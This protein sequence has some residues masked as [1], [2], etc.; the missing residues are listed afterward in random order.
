MPRN[1]K[2]DA[3]GD[4]GS[5]RRKKS[6]PGAPSALPSKS[7][8]LDFLAEVNGDATRRDIARAFNIK[9]DARTELRSLLKEMNEEGL[10]NKTGPKRVQTPDAL[11]PILPLDIVSANADGDLLC[12]PSKW[13]SETTPPTIWLPARDAARQKPALG[14]GDR[15]LAR[16]RLA[17]DDGY[18]ASVIKAIGRGA[19]RFLAV[20][21]A[22]KFGGIAE[23]VE[24]RVRQKFTIDREDTKGAQ[25]GDLV[26]AE[27]APRRG[28]S[29]TKAR[30]Q[31]IAG[32]IDD[33]NAFS[34]MALANHNV[35]MDMPPAAVKEA[36]KAKAPTLSA[37]DDLR[38]TPL[39]TIDPADAKDHDD[40]VWAAPDD[41]PNNEGGFQVI[42][43]IA[44]VSWFVREGTALDREARRRGNSVYLPDRVVP[45]LPERLS[46]GLCSL[47]VG[48]DRPCLAV[49]MIIDANGHK[50]SHRFMRALMRS[51]SKLSYEEAQALIENPTD[52]EI[53]QTI[54]HLKNAFDARWRERTNRAPLDLD[55]PERRVV[56]NKEG[57]VLGVT[58][59]DRF[60]A[61]RVIEEFMILANIAAAET[62]EQKKTEQM[63]R[64][65]E[66]PDDEKLA[67]TRDYLS[68][69]DYSLIKGGAVRPRHF[70]QLLKL[71]ESRDQKE[72][73]SQIVLRSQMQAYYGVENF[74]HFGLKPGEILPFHLPHSALCGFNDPPRLGQSLQFR[75][76]RPIASRGKRTERDRGIYFRYGASRHGGRA[77]GDGSL[78]CKLPRRTRG[79]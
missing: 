76:R 60:D 12:I 36:E 11:P 41:D 74:G 21:R 16:V 67:A 35:P 72:L 18:E 31:S 68:S 56:L 24:K 7:A 40:A 9:G 5:P 34:L 26:W 52:N 59:K 50:K 55:L 43:A 66:A 32:S 49:K 44:D 38:A 13:R 70:N 30:I 33:R 37:R 65:H 48:E 69:L 78:S 3:P 1:K 10:L 17:G 62:L 64:V 29:S 63:Y 22:R 4:A 73:I 25:D 20:F 71:A 28:S 53:G 58:R 15:I 51:A 79:R 75:R 47:R 19:Q 2:N 42:V 57:E 45:M 14:E 23:P 8:I 27:A 46:N 54:R 39:L 6:A 77:G 61:H